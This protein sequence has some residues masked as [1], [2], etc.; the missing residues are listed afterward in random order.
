MNAAHLV[1][2]E[3]A[4]VSLNLN[5]GLSYRILICADTYLE[6]MT[7]SFLNQAGTSF[8]QDTLKEGIAIT[9]L[10]VKQS[11]AYQ[12]ELEIPEKK[13]ATGIIRNG[14][15]TILIGFKD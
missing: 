10:Q 4:S 15:V 5:K 3:S 13:N 9:D 11:G 2:G 7:Y 14:C 6:G 8:K 1:P 12:I